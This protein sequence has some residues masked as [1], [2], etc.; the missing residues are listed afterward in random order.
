[1]ERVV[2]DASAPV[3]L[4]L[5]GWECHLIFSNLAGRS[6]HPTARH[7]MWVFDTWLAQTLQN[8]HRQNTETPPFPAGP[9]RKGGCFPL[10]L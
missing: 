8:N 10:D 2:K 7:A 9:F 1:M 5:A 6:S 4:C 3:A